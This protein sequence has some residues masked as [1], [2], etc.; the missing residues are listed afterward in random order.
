M[1]RDCQG[2]KM[3]A[4][5]NGFIVLWHLILVD[6][7]VDEYHSALA[8]FPLEKIKIIKIDAAHI[9]LHFLY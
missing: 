1:N 8:Q 6:N 7:K 5:L 2:L 4:N 9:Y 3:I